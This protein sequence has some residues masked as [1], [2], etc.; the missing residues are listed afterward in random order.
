MALALA[1]ARGIYDAGRGWVGLDVDG[2]RTEANTLRARLASL[3]AELAGVRQQADAAHSTLQ[4]ERTAQE[5]LVARIRTLESENARLRE[6]MLVFESLAGSGA[7]G[8]EQAF[9]INRLAVEPDAEPDRYRFRMLI[10]RQGGKADADVSGSYQIVAAI[11]RGGQGATITFPSEARAD[12]SRLTFRHFQRVDGVLS[13]TPG[14]RLVS[15][16]ARFVQDGQIR[17]RA[18]A[19]L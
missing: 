4:I 8:V 18:T 14:A 10:V 11:D 17:A 3:E 13:L 9:R 15:I 12:G 7:A 6:D 2:M 19:L 1:A 16:E 5:Q